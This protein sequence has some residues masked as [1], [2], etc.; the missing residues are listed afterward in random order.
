MI[1]SHTSDLPFERDAT[2][3]F[4]PWIIALMV[5][6]A[7][8]AVAGAMLVGGA[9]S[10]WSAGLSGTLTVQVPASEGGDADTRRRLDRAVEILRKTPGVARAEALDE[11]ATGVL[12]EPWL[13]PNAELAGLPLP[14]L[15]DVTVEKGVRLDAAA[16]TRRLAIEIPGALVDDHSEW[17]EDAIAFARAVELVSAAVVLL[18]GL[19]AMATVVFTART[20]LAL[21]RSVI[22]VL[23][24]IGA[25]DGFIARQFQRHALILG[26]K[27]GIGALALA[28]LTLLA[29]GRVVGDIRVFGLPEAS[30]GAVQWAVLAAI[31]L[32]AAAVA[33][34]TARVTVLRTLARMP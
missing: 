2:S 32:A 11:Q 34:L 4:L 20:G 25:H 28:A 7:V 22:E 3:R 5:Y 31:P 21:H 8:L 1:F 19:A 16:L 27:G 17:L 18:T 23:H 6:L 9:V 14:R 33:M 12:L 10:S 29:A 15:I 26:L 13:G 24:L 30:L